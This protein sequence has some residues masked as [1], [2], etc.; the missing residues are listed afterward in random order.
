MRV[1]LVDDED[2]IRNGII[3]LLQ[4]LDCPVKVVGEADDG[5]EGFEKL[6]L[7]QPDIA[8]IDI[9]M[10]LKNGLELMKDAYHQRVSPKTKFVIVTAHSEFEYAQTAIRYGVYDFLLKPLS[11][12]TLS[13]LFE[14][15]LPKDSEH[16]KVPS[17]IG[18]LKCRTF[19]ESKQIKQDLVI[20]M[21]EYIGMN[22]MK[23]IRLLETAAIFKVTPVYASNL[24]K[25]TTGVTFISYIQQLRI[26]I[27]KQ[28]L[29]TG[30]YKINEV[31]F[32]V[33]YSN[34]T[35]FGRVFRAVTGLTPNDYVREAQ[36]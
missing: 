5:I 36:K 27:A 2:T 34:L 15:L 23:D 26:E 19:I 13:E 10:P 8:L 9:R 3:Y 12:G 22:Y 29:A 18:T 21:L 30:E 11:V 4:Q 25:K 6:R 16:E 1:L 31:S 35:Y 32:F 17:D 24:F 28:L 14:R 7:L 33:G 20:R